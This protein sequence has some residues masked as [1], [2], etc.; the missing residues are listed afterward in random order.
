M[1]SPTIERSDIGEQLLVLPHNGYR[2]NFNS[3]SMSGRATLTIRG[4]QS[5][6][7]WF[8]QSSAAEPVPQR[9]V[10]FS[11][12]CLTAVP[13]LARADAAYRLPPCFSQFSTSACVTW[14]RGRAD[15]TQPTSPAVRAPETRCH[16]AFSGAGGSSSQF[17]VLSH[18]LIVYSIEPVGP[19]HT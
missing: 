4:V 19:L 13:L 18:I 10:T 14:Q 2:G 9:G 11:S 6:A 15:G 16:P 7:S 17:N 12:I 5:A 3:S 8:C 1:R